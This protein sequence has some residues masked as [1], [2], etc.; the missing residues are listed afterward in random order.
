MKRFETVPITKLIAF[1]FVFVAVPLVA[2]FLAQ[3]GVRW[4]YVIPALI[5]ITTILF[6]QFYVWSR[7]HAEEA[8]TKLEKAL[9]TTQVGVTITDV[10]GKIIYLNSAE[11]RMHGYD[12]DE[13]VGKIVRIFASP[14]IWEVNP[15][16]LIREMSSW[17]RESENLRKD[18]KSFPVHLISDVIRNATGDPIGI[19]TVCE[20]VTERS[21]AET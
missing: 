21:L 9:Q 6:R 1:Y 18:G 20:D 2:F 7:K 15:P 4:V 16:D 14:E 8:L 19:V 12:P 10:E 3:H 11:A 5:L 13:L 17:R